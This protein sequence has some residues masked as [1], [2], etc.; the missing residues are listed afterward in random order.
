MQA[1]LA[2]QGLGGRQLRQLVY[3]GQRQTLARYPNVDPS[4]PA[5]GGWAYVD[6]VVVSK[7]VSRAE[8]SKRSLR[9]RANDIRDW[10]SVDGGEVFIYPR[11][12]Y[13]NFIFP[14]ASFNRGAKTLTL[15]AD[16]PWAL[17][18]GDR[19]F[20]QNL[21][22]ELDSPGEWYLD[23]KSSTLYF[24]PPG[25]LESA[26]VT[27]PVLEAVVT[28]VGARYLQIRGFQIEAN[29]TSAIYVRDS[30]DCVIAGNSIRN[31]GGRASPAD[32]AV[33]VIGGER[34]GVVGNDIFDV[35]SGGILLRGGE[36][37]SLSPGGHYAE[38]NHIYRTGVLYKQGVGVVL[39]G[40]GNRASRNLLHDM[41]RMAIHVSG[42]DHVVELNRIHHVNLETEDTGAIYVVGVDWLS[43]RGTII[44]NNVVA[45][46][47]GFGF[48]F[49]AGRW[50]TP[51]MAFG[52]YLD[53]GASGVDVAGNIVE[54]ASWA[55][56][57]LH[58][59]RESV[60]ENN[61]LLDSGLQQIRLMSFGAT[62]PFLAEMSRNYR[63]YST[64]PAWGKYRGF[65]SAPPETALQMSNNTF[66]RNVVAYGGPKAQYV[67]EQGMPMEATRFESNIVFD[68]DGPVSTS[69]A[70]V[71]KPLGWNEWQAKGMDRNSLVTD[72]KVTR[73]A[74]GIPT[75]APDSPAFGVGF[76]PI[77]VD[78]I[79]PYPSEDRAS[80]PVVEPPTVREHLD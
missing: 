69:Q 50:R 75:L 39:E 34:N 26:N 71:R 11:Y 38:N 43:G 5:S 7:Y 14:I 20:V 18:P 40:V 44:R 24:W 74:N 19:F 66:A 33:A 4:R 76:Q 2:S 35:G 54:R 27:V 68:R 62:N 28:I 64:S 1:D 59:A 72:P 57:Y 16:S 53:D 42:N 46:S 73:T 36:Q 80:W 45:D 10:T 30:S 47:V 49:E 29:D 60:I 37:R 65:L 15:G 78:R 17:R 9:L 51:Y 52:I 23:R 63:E 3:Q 25:P 58:S 6:G 79:G 31:S 56:V 70:G 61:L 55:A 32:Y 67:W 22:A 48:D 8:D 13:W 21:L 12:N 41:P 77:P